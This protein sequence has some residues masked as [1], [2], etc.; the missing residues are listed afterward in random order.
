MTKSITDESSRIFKGEF[1]IQTSI[2]SYDL[3]GNKLREINTVNSSG[4]GAFDS[5]SEV[6]Y[7]FDEQGRLR[8]VKAPAGTQPDSWVSAVNTARIDTLKYKFDE[9]GNRRQAYLDTT[10]HL[11]AR[12]VI[13]NWYKYDL[14]GRVLV[15]DGYKNSNN[16]VVAG[17]VGALSKGQALSYDA[18]GRRLSSEQWQKTISSSEF[19]QHNEYAYNDLGQVLSS[20]MRQ[21]TRGLNADSAQEANA[22]GAAGLVFASTYDVRGNR[23]S[24]VDYNASG[25]AT[26]STSYSYRGDGQA[27]SQLTYTIASGVQ[28]NSQSSYFNEAG[29][30]D[31]VGNQKSYRYVIYTSSGSI[32]YRGNNF[33]T[34]ELF[35][36]YKDQRTIATLS[37]YSSPGET[38]FYYSDRGQLEA[39]NINNNDARHFISN[40]SGDVFA[41]NKYWGTSSTSYQNFIYTQGATLARYGRAST[42]EITDTFTP[43]SPD[44]PARTPSSYVVNQGDTLA[45]IA[46]TLWG[47]SKMWYLIADANGLAT[48]AVL[49]PGDSL[50]IPNVVSSTHNDATTFKPY[51]LDEIIGNTT[52][53]AKPLP[54]PP[55]KGKKNKCGGIAKVVMVVVAV[56][57]T[58]FTAGAALAAIAPAAA[59][60]VGTLGGLASAGMTAL[61]GGSWA[62]VGA[63]AIGGAV[64]SAASQMAGKAMGVVDDFSWRQVAAGGLTAGVTAGMTGL[65]QAGQLG[66]LA[67]KTTQAMSHA[68]YGY[69]AQGVFNYASSQAIN[70]IVGLDTTFSWSGLAASVVGANIGG[71]VGNSSGIGGMPG[72]MIKGQI[73]AHASAAINDKWFGGSRPNYGQVAADAFGNTLANFAVDQMQR[74]GTSEVNQNRLAAAGDPFGEEAYARYYGMEP[75]QRSDAA[76]PYDAW[77]RSQIDNFDLAYGRGDAPTLL[78]TQALGGPQEAE[79]LSPLFSASLNSDT[80]LLGTNRAEFNSGYFALDMANAAGAS[81]YNLGAYGINAAWAGLNITPIAYSA[82][83]GRTFDQ[84]SQD[85]FVLGAQ[86]GPYGVGASRLLAPNALR[87]GAKLD[88]LRPA[89]TQPLRRLGEVNEDVPI[90][91]NKT[92]IA[93]NVRITG[94]LDPD[95]AKIYAEINAARSNLVKPRKPTSDNTN[96]GNITTNVDGTTTVTLKSSNKNVNNLSVIYDAEGFPDFGPFLYDKGVNTVNLK[97]TG[98]RNHDFALANQL[99]G[100]GS[101]AKS[102]PK[103]FTW[104][105][106]QD[107]GVMQLVRT[108]VHKLSPHTG[109]VSIW[110]KAFGFDYM[111][112]SNAANPFLE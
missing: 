89:T 95:T 74:A 20:S 31:A 47:D 91:P 43:I 30:L 62:A 105:H 21:I 44:Y 75:G 54:P 72:A 102:T 92:S 46:Q 34:Y 5:A 8:E 104:H 55:P 39:I 42:P 45:S 110:Q 64:G 57:V 51:N 36:T 19:Y 56:V 12:K 85:I 15:I 26:G 58:V 61:A 49:P 11:G 66:T 29:M 99:A 33:K 27:A 17:K 70:R 112:K 52:P 7:N 82:V 94:E 100:F 96:I 108:D 38:N 23:Q 9:L 87:L 77:R 90:V 35:D 6:R 4:F 93:S 24:Q 13:D 68:K 73:S 18:N 53:T 22:I 109:G 71:Y 101:T 48:S 76:L 63:A 86:L 106:H 67:Q 88:N 84:A 25:V 1:C 80:D 40:R 14:E 2:Y 103:N 28:K 16:Q 81:L 97:L 10:D 65:A 60:A 78:I 107:L 98:N 37:I 79:G 41:I 83:S 69:T 50:K 111:P 32:N 3:S 59:G